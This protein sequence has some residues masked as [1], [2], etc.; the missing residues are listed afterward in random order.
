MQVIFTKEEKKLLKDLKT[1]Y[2]H[3]IMIK[4][5]RNKW[6][7]RKKKNKKKNKNQQKMI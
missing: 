1:N 4:I 5:I 3:F 7:M 6:R 2:F